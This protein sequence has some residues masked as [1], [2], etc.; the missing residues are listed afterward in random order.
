M[1]AAVTSYDLLIAGGGIAGAA[2]G[3]SMA[4]AGAHV[5]IVEKEVEFRD[6]IR[7]E[8]VLPWGSV[9]AKLLGIYDLLLSKCGWEALFENFY[10]NGVAVPPRDYRATTPE[11]TCIL[12]F[13]HPAMQEVLLTA[14]ADAGAE[15]WRGA[16]IKDVEVTDKVVARVAGKEREG[17]VSAR[18]VVG[19]D[20]RESHLATMLNFERFRDP[21]HL[22][23]AGVQVACDIELD[24][25]MYFFVDGESGRGGIINKN[26]PGNYR[27]YL[28]HHKDVLPRRLSGARDYQT[29]FQHFREIGMPGEW[30]DHGSPHGI[31]ASFDGAHRWIAQ[32]VRGACVLIGDAAGATDPAWGNGLSRTL[33]DVRLL[34]DR[35]L[36]DPNWTAAAGAYAADHNDFFGRLR[37]A[38]KLDAKMFYT[39]GAEAEARRQKAM[40]MMEKDPMLN[41]DVVGLGPEARVPK[42]LVRLLAADLS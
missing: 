23:I 34:R 16:S 18:L 9:E 30:L 33:R 6:R 20:G 17:T 37:R 7:G 25:A 40:E 13:F 36:N 42:A 39:L 14:A 28:V 3:R 21:E 4:L 15:V 35:L 1:G 41:P 19:A 11:G 24:A 10:Y 8:V 26:G 38:E 2:L 31:L 27:A 5:L 22:Y 29:I 12:T 32:P